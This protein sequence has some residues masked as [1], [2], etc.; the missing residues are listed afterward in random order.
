MCFGSELLFL[1]FVCASSSC[2][3]LDLTTGWDVA[4][5]SAYGSINFEECALGIR[6]YALSSIIDDFLQQQYFI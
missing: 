3:P 5:D 2:L 6:I 1:D 4:L